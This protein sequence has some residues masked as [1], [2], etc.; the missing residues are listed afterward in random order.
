[1]ASLLRKAPVSAFSDEFSTRWS[2]VV[3]RGKKRIFKRKADHE[4]IVKEFDALIADRKASDD[5]AYAGLVT[6][7][8]ARYLESCA[9]EGGKISPQQAGA[10]LEASEHFWTAAHQDQDHG[11]TDPP[12]IL[13]IHARDAQAKALR[14]FERSGNPWMQAEVLLRGAMHLRKLGEHEE[15]GY[16]AEQSGLVE[17]N[18]PFDRFVALSVAAACYATAKMYVMLERVLCSMKDV[19]K[20]AVEEDSS[21]SGFVKGSVVSGWTSSWS[22]SGVFQSVLGL[23]LLQIVLGKHKKAT[24]LLRDDL[25]PLLVVR[26]VVPLVS[27][28]L[29]DMIDRRRGRKDGASVEQVEEWRGVFKS[30]AQDE[31]VGYLVDQVCL[32]LQLPPNWDWSKK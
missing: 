31:F 21:W 7:S 2:N 28:M 14:W 9:E 20:E 25:K 5:F 27:D 30:I 19:A 23:V 18:D 22:E 16:M 26:D 13:R 15:A 4:E 32:T 6:M 17:K 12:E 10:Y 1:M 3:Q 24:Q 11:C 8:L 29:E